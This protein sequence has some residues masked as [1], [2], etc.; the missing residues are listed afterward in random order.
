MFPKFNKTF[1]LTVF[2]IRMDVKKFS[3]IIKQSVKIAK[4]YR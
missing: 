4:L 3:K 1:K 2:I